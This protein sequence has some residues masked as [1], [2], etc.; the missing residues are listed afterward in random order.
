MNC[1]PQ[2]RLAKLFADVAALADEDGT[3]RAQ[4]AEEV[5][6]LLAADHVALV[7]STEPLVVFAELLIAQARWH[8][9]REDAAVFDAIDSVMPAE[10][11]PR[12][13]DPHTPF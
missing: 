12:T 6:E 4:L 7:C 13:A 8:R 11:A 1:D 10:P 2:R 9:A 3:P 5:A